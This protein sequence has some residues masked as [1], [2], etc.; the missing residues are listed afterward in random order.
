MVASVCNSNSTAQAC[1]QP[2]VQREG[3]HLP[4]G[5]LL[6]LHACKRD[7]HTAAMKPFQLHRASTAMAAVH[8]KVLEPV[9]YLQA[10]ASC[11]ADQA[12]N[13]SMNARS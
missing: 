3:L 1:E 6:Y 2:A 11:I 13:N 9:P 8:C 4:T 12:T 10:T 7:A 5:S